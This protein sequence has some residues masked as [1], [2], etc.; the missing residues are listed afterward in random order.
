ME[1]IGGTVDKRGRR[2]KGSQAWLEAAAEL[3]RGTSVSVVAGLIG[4]QEAT[5]WAWKK[6]PDFLQVVEACWAEFVKQASK[7]VVAKILTRD[8]GEVKKVG[9]PEVPGPGVESGEIGR[10]LREDTI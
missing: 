9:R 6:D 5:V 8:G 7:Q 3:S 1:V 10:M 4:A 2:Y